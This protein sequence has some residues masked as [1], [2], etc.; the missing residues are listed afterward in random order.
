MRLVLVGPPGAGK[1][2]QAERL[3][4][5][6]GV[7][8]IST[9]ELFRANV[10]NG[11]A[12][13]VEAKQYLDAGEL[14]PDSVTNEMVRQRLA[15]SDAVVGFLLD[16]FPR[17]VAQADV[18]TEILREQGVQLDAVVQ[19]DIAEDVVVDRLLARGRSDDTE[20]VIR[21]RQQ[22]YRSET[23]PLLDYYRGVLITIDAVGS[24]E[25]ITERAL[26]ALR[27]QS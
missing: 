3:S 2:T 27:A 17:N 19:F 4:Q 14:V 9:G 11:T 15:E 16:G 20:E 22:I 24:V 5:Q 18:L 23:A 1:G 26:K 10:G 6:L 8:H 7:P 12:L 21:R 25:D 13:G